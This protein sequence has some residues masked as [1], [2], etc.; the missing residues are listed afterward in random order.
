MTLNPVVLCLRLRLLRLLSDQLLVIKD[1][2]L[3][4]KV[5]VRVRFSFFLSFSLLPGFFMF[6]YQRFIDADDEYSHSYFMG[7]KTCRSQCSKTSRCRIQISSSKRSSFPSSSSY[8]F[9]I[10]SNISFHSSFRFYSSY[11]LFHSS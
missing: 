7:F 1:L 4:V 2:E 5:L 11:L 9:N 3:V 8:T 6:L 10:H